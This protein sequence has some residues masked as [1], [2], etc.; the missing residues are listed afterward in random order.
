MT[1]L[2][3]PFFAASIIACGNGTTTDD[4]VDPADCPTHDGATFELGSGQLSYEPIADGQRLPI[5]AGSQGGCHF[6]LSVRTDGFAPRR[7]K[8]QYEVFF[9]DDST[10]TGSRSSFTVR[11]RPIDGMPGQCENLGVTAFLIEPWN[12]EEKR[13]VLEVNVTDDE[14]RAATRRK[15]VIADWPDSLPSDGCKPRN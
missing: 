6:F 3:V 13:L 2:L 7:F 10:T 15:T 1:R 8:I 14:G 5:N 11:L 9:A 4:D 12:L